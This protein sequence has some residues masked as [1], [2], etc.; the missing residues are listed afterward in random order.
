MHVGCPNTWFLF[1][2]TCWDTLAHLEAQDYSLNDSDEE[3]EGV[4]DI[5]SSDSE[6]STAH[7]DS[8]YA[9]LRARHKGKATT[10]EKGKAVEMGPDSAL[11]ARLPP[12][13][14]VIGASPIAT[15]LAAAHHMRLCKRS[16][17]SPTSTIAKKEKCPSDAVFEDAIVVGKAFIFCR[18]EQM[19]PASDLQVMDGASAILPTGLNNVIQGLVKDAELLKSAKATHSKEVKTLKADLTKLSAN[20]ATAQEG[21]KKAMETLKT[22]QEDVVR[23]FK[24]LED[25]HEEA[26]AHASM[27]AQTVVDQW[28]EGELGL[29]R[30]NY[31]NDTQGTEGVTL[32]ASMDTLGDIPMDNAYLESATNVDFV[33]AMDRASIPTLTEVG[34]SDVVATEEEEDPY[35]ALQLNRQRAGAPSATCLLEHRRQVRAKLPQPEA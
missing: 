6:A 9:A 35:D 21:W 3:L 17:D 8:R 5:S 7:M 10:A 27:H 23:A 13:G 16:S 31:P 25:F 1:Q 32:N 12:V 20:L 26:M 29:S 14:V 19:I 28:F 22:A 18:L 4:V 34:Q 2:S 33:T 24:E 30:T 15:A 11:A